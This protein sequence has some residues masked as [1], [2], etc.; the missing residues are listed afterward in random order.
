MG[1]C[2]LRPGFFLLNVGWVTRSWEDKDA[3]SVRKCVRSEIFPGSLGS[4]QLDRGSQHPSVAG[5]LTANG[6]GKL[7][8]LDRVTSPGL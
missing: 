8:M 7:P 4:V 2:F 3:T 6:A 5:A 1:R